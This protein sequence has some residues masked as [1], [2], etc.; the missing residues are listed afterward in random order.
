MD[1]NFEDKFRTLSYPAVDRP[2]GADALGSAGKTVPYPEMLPPD[3]DLTTRP[4]QSEVRK[5]QRTEAHQI[6]VGDIIEL[7]SLKYEI[8]EILSEEGKTAEAVI[9]KVKD[10]KNRVFALKLYYEFKDQHLEP[11]SDTL[12]RIRELDANGLLF[13]FDFGTGPNKY[14]DKY[15]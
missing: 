15:C 3:E 7:N 10:K 4:Y 14:L 13:L 11:G 9:Y 2:E 8:L 5:V 12:Q 1:E 6:G